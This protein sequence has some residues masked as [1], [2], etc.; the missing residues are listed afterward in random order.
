[1]KIV[2]KNKKVRHEYEIIKTYEAGIVLKGSEIKSIRTGRVQIRDSFAKVDYKGEVMLIN[3][4]ISKYD[5]AH[6]V[7]KFDETASRKLLLHR[8]EI[9]KLKES[10][11]EKGFSLVPTMLYFKH[12]RLKVELAVVRGKKNY[13]K[14]QTLKERTQKREMDKMIKDRS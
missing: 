5:N 7:D 6:L 11:Q 4:H 8:I 12:N 3:M 10:L 14:R 9:R 1:M 2:A 13:D